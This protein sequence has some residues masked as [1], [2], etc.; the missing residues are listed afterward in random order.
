MREESVDFDTTK[1]LFI[2]GDNLDALKLL[3]ES[4]LGKIKL[5]YIDPPYNTGSDLL[6]DDDFSQAESEYLSGTGQRAADGS[7]LVANT[8]SSGR[9]HSRWLSTLYPR[10][11]TARNLLAADGLIFISIDDHEVANLKRLCD[12]VLGAE[13]F[14]ATFAWQKTLTRRND[15]TF[16]STAHEYLICFARNAQLASFNRIETDDKQRATYTNRDQDPRGDWLAVPFHAPN[17]RPNLTYPITTPGGRV[18]MPP[19][20]RCWSTTKEQYQELRADNRLYFGQDGNGMAQR[21]K[22]W[23]EREAGMVP[24]TWWPHDFAGENRGATRE[25]KDLFDGE[26]VFTAPKPT[27]L[28]TR[29]LEMVPTAGGDTILDFFAGSGTTAD[30]VQQWNSSGKPEWHHISVQLAEECEA[31]SVAAGLGY[32][33]IADVA[34][35]RI[36]RAGVRTIVD[37]GLSGGSLDVGFRALRLDSSSMNDV[38]L[39]PDETGQAELGLLE[40]SVKADRTSEDLLFQVLLDWGL[41]LSLPIEQVEVEGQEVFNVEEGALVAC[42]E[43]SVKPETIRAVAKRAPLRAVFRDS[44]FDSDKDRINAEQIFAEVSPDTDV[45]VI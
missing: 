4:Y 41:E 13:N 35:E 10:L 22:F 7:R 30:A 37:A 31:K 32:Q 1:N 43:S 29:I 28:I 38:L 33:T 40:G 18:L 11:K 36:R 9:F 16:S 20:G 21:K 42:F 24:W 15:A 45:K 8:E 19:S 2:E 3:Q 14:I 34:R 5:I 23:S 17:I 27:R 39:T 25:I 26:V 6:Y 12:E 44:A